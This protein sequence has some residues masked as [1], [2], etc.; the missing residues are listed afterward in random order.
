MINSLLFLFMKNFKKT[1]IISI[2][3]GLILFILSFAFYFNFSYMGARDR[4]IEKFILDN[5][6]MM[7]IL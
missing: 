5:F 1:T 2:A 4:D 7:I 6:I 3:F